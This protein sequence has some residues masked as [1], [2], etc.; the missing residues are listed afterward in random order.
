MNSNF[1]KLSKL[2]GTLVFAAIAL[3]TTHPARAQF[4]SSSLS[5]PINV[6]ADGPFSSVCLTAA[7]P[8]FLSK[9]QQVGS[10]CKVPGCFGTMT[11]RVVEDLFEKPRLRV[12][13]EVR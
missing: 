8:S 11:G 6:F 4:A 3:L 5:L 13:S 9:P 7:G 12:K 1:K 2:T 10:N